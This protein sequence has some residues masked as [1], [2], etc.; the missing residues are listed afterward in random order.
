MKKSL[1]IPIIIVVIIAIAAITFFLFRGIRGK[2]ASPVSSAS[3][4]TTNIEDAKEPS[5]A[6]KEYISDAGFSFKYPDDVSLEEREVGDD[7]IYED[8]SL[9]FSQTK[10]SIV[11][12]IADTKIKSLEEL[13]PQI[14]TAKKIKIGTLAGREINDNN[15]QTA[16]VLDQGILFTIEVDSQDKYWLAVYN[17]ILSSFSFVE[18]EPSSDAASDDIILEEESVE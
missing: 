6:H 8:L 4:E 7:A 18:A 5:T 1:A 17:T 10:G 2:T 9:T 13:F 11:I 15:K 14:S 16:V 3:L 12:K